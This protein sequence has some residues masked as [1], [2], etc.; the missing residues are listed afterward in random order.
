MVFL[1]QQPKLRPVYTQKRANINNI[2]PPRPQEDSTKP[3]KPFS[4][5]KELLH[6]TKLMYKY[7]CKV[8]VT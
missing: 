8:Q 4:L 7:I 6:Y 5:E 1:W 3:W 2:N